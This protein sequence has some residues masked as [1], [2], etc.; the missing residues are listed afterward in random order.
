MTEAANPEIFENRF[1][2]KIMD[3]HLFIIMD[4]LNYREKDEIAAAASMTKTFNDLLARSW[5]PL[6]DAQ[7][8][9][10]NAQAYKATQDIRK[11]KLHLLSRQLTKSIAMDMT[12]G[13]TSRLVNEAE[14]YLD[15]LSTFI[16]NKK[17]FVQPIPLHLLWLIDAAGHAEIISNG[18]NYSNTDLKYKTFSYQ[19]E[20]VNLYVR[21]AEMKGFFRIGENNFPSFEQFN[22]DVSERL[23]DFTEFFVELDSKI[24]DDRVPT[25]VTSLMLDHMYREECYYLTKLATVCTIKPPNCDPTV[26]AFDLPK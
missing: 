12:S 2:L 22:A 11:F 6:S 10:L 1:W 26:S 15:I 8:A 14:Y 18:L 7:L 20:F 3:D 21:A 16:K 19:K 24:R 5:Q 9:D 4:A 13:L 17:F 25:T 23:T